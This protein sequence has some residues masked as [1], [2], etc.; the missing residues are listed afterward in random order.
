M[1]VEY[2]EMEKTAYVKIIYIYIYIY[3]NISYNNYALTIIGTSI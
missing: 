1:P 3:I 2:S